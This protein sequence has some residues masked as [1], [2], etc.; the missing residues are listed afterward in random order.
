MRD[1]FTSSVWNFWRWITDILLAKC[2]LGRERR[3]TAVFAGYYAMALI[4]IS[5]CCKVG[6][7]CIYTYISPCHKAQGALTFF[8][9]LWFIIKYCYASYP[10]TQNRNAGR[11]YFMLSSRCWS[12]PYS[13]FNTMHIQVDRWWEYYEQSA[14]DDHLDVPLNSYN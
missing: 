12:T 14:V 9:W 6:F 5:W 2:H 1:R 3:G 11:C 13:P 7:H 10:F 8:Y 4:I